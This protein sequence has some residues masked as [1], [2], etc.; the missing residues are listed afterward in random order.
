MKKLLL[1]ALAAVLLVACGKDDNCTQS[2]F[3]GVYNVQG[4]GCLLDST[5]VKLTA[6]AN[7]TSDLNMEWEDGS[8]TLTLDGP[9]KLTDCTGSLKL[10][11]EPTETDLTMN[12]TLDGNTLKITYT[13]KFFSTQI[14]CTETFKK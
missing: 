14:N 2:D 11:D 13:G 10:V 4:K 5:N 7:G 1:S 8:N 9:L 3:V 12:A 6:T